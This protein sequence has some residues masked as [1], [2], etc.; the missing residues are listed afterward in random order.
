MQWNQFCMPLFLS[1]ANLAFQLKFR[2]SSVRNTFQRA[3]HIFK[4]L[5]NNFKSKHVDDLIISIQRIFHKIRETNE[6]EIISTLT[7]R[8]RI[9]I[10]NTV[11]VKWT[12]SASVWSI[13]L[14]ATNQVSKQKKKQFIQ[15][16]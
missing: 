4:I 6:Q 2:D 5:I 12:Q 3:A 9:I 1:I 14:S 10:I 8:R 13:S 16:F 11:R 7:Y 15:L